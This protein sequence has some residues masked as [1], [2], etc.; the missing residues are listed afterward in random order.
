MLGLWPKILYCSALIYSFINTLLAN[1]LAY[2]FPHS[3]IIVINKLV[4]LVT[5]LTLTTGVFPL[6]FLAACTAIIVVV[7]KIL[8][9]CLKNKEENQEFNFHVYWSVQF[10][11][12]L[13]N[14]TVL[15]ISYLS[16]IFSFINVMKYSEYAIKFAIAI[17]I[18]SYT[19]LPAL[20]ILGVVSYIFDDK[21]SDKEQKTRIDYCTFLLSVF[22]IVMMPITT[23][24]LFNEGISLIVILGNMIAAKVLGSTVV[25]TTAASLAI[26]ITVPSL[27]VIS[28]IIAGRLLLNFIDS[29]IVPS[30]KRTLCCAWKGCKAGVSSVDHE[31]DQVSMANLRR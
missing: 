9:L 6:L 23:A 15:W 12:T 5:H 8:Y 3:G 16:V 1:L 21:I 22:N 17:S 11:A 28:L 27:T 13:I 30:V 20:I 29:N 25:L 2:L 10:N 19:A 7:C 14:Y 31:I 18:C 24:C 4:Y 26:G